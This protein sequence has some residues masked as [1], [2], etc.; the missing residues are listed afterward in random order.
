M[1]CDFKQLL[2]LVHFAP[3][4]STPDVVSMSQC[5]NIELSLYAE[6]EQTALYKPAL[7]LMS[8]DTRYKCHVVRRLSNVINLDEDKSSLKSECY[9]W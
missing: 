7:T 4:L 5:T 1:C 8:Y 3:K 6:Y 9:A 2:H